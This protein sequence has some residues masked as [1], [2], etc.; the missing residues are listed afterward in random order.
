MGEV[1]SKKAARDRII[2]D[3]QSTVDAAKARAAVPGGEVWAVA[4]PRLSGVLALYRTT[5]GKWETARAEFAPLAAALDV[6]NEAADDVVRAQSDLIWNELGRPANDPVFELL[7]PGG[8]GFYADASVEDQPQMMALL[9]ELLE[10][11]LSAKLA[12]NVAPKVAAIRDAAARLSAAVD[13]ARK[14]RA[15]VKL[16]DRMLTAVARSAQLELARLKRYWK[17]EG[18]SEADIHTVIPDRPRGYGV[19]PASPDPAP[20]VVPDPIDT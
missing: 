3:V 14:P 19:P 2:E 7:F 17:S 12:A 5:R 10:S 13:A 4:E 16:Y 9:A 8:S 1:I 20:P 6:A 18:L 11:N 15:T